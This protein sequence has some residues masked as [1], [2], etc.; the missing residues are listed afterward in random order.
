VARSAEPVDKFN[1]YISFA[2]GVKAAGVFCIKFAY[3]EH[4]FHIEP[5]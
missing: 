5:I 1:S 3:P 2:L 4:F